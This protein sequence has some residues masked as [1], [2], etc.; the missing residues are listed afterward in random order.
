MCPRCGD[1]SSSEASSKQQQPPQQRFTEQRTSGRRMGMIQQTGGD[2]KS[3]LKTSR[4]AKLH[5][6]EGTTDSPSHRRGSTDRIYVDHTYRDHLHDPS[7]LLNGGNP[8]DPNHPSDCRKK[9]PRG[10]VTITFP[11]KLHIMLQACAD[12]GL[13]HIVSWLPHGRYVRVSREFGFPWE[14]VGISAASRCA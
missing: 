12:E 14:W 11:E 6:R 13:E 4:Q 5:S 2:G 1:S 9:G 3:R 8:L 10:G 7:G